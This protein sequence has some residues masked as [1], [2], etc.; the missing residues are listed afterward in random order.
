[1]SAFSNRMKNIAVVPSFKR[2]LFTTD[3]MEMTEQNQRAK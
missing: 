3:R 2:V 1:M